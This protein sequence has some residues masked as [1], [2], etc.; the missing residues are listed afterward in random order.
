[1]LLELREGPAMWRKTK[2]TTAEALRGCGARCRGME[3]RTK[4][5]RLASTGG[6]RR[7]YPSQQ[8]VQPVRF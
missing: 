1:M 3:A 6:A 4:E 2:Q 5:H 8:M 7:T